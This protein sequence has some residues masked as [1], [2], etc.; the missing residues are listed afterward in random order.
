MKNGRFWKFFTIIGAVIGLVDSLYLSWIKITHTT[1]LCLPGIG[2]CETVNT[3]RY[4]QIYGI[5]VAYFGA[6][7]YLV[8][9]VVLYLEEKQPF[10]TANGLLV[11][12]GVSLLGVLYS[13]YLTYIEI[14]VIHAICPF[15]VLSAVIMLGIFGSTLVRLNIDQSSLKF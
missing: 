3:S 8:L 7:A 2:D 9:L 5:P 1:A 10:F 4:S 14:A 6:A 12:F 15:C 11:Q 13:A